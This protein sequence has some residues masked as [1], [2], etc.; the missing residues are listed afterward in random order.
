MTRSRAQKMMGREGRKITKRRDLEDNE[1][2]DM[3]GD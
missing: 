1:N 3:E 2:T